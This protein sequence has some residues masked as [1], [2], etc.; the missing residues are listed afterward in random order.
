MDRRRIERTLLAMVFTAWVAASVAMAQSHSIS[1]TDSSHDAS[2]SSPSLAEGALEQQV[3]DWAF[4]ALLTVLYVSAAPLIVSLVV[5][6]AVSILQ[7]ATQIQ[8]Q[9]LSF[10]P[11]ILAVFATLLLFSGTML[12]LLRNY[13]TELWQVLEKIRL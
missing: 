10:V 11:K 12:S 5:G 8:E 1:M 13:T 6:L 3:V 9:T 7:A 2:S 4:R